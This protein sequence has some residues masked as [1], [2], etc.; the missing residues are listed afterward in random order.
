MN[1]SP[2]SAFGAPRRQGLAG[3][4]VASVPHII[5]VSPSELGW[6]VQ[7]PGLSEPRSFGSGAVAERFAR[8][9]AAAP[10]LSGEGEVWIRGRDGALLGRWRDG[11]RTPDLSAAA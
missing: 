11:G 9:L 2:G 7:A 10:E 1:L 8:S 4:W 5:I 3:S 6:V